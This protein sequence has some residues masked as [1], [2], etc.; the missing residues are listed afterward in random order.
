MT[1]KNI[2]FPRTTILAAWIMV[3]SLPAAY[4][5]SGHQETALIHTVMFSLNSAPDSEAAQ[6]F[7]REGKEI[8]TRIPGVEN[9]EVRRQVSGKNPYQFGFSMQFADQAAFERYLEHP[10]HT[11]FVKER[12]D[13]EVADFLEADYIL[14]NPD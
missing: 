2:S 3:L 7:L 11:S 13:R 14:C 4:S 1:G 9:F 8:L 10:L 12:W 6:E 5:A